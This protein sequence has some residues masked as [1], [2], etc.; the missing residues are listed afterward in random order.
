MAASSS[1]GACRQLLETAVNIAFLD[2]A[3]IQKSVPAFF[4]NVCY[5]A[6]F[7]VSSLTDTLWDL[8]ALALRTISTGVVAVAAVAGAVVDVGCTVLDA[9]MPKSVTL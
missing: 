1:L 5:V 4:T 9:C 8:A 7:A 3:N 6:Y 2:V